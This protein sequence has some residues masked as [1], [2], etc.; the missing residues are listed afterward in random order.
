MIVD[1]EF[2][3]EEAIITYWSIMLCQWELIKFIFNRMFYLGA[4]FTATCICGSIF[5]IPRWFRYTNIFRSSV[6]SLRWIVKQHSLLSWN[7]LEQL[8]TNFGSTF[9]LL[10]FLHLH[11]YL[12]Y[13]LPIFLMNFLTFHILTWS[14][15]TWTNQTLQIK[16]VMI[17]CS[18][19][20]GNLSW[21]IFVL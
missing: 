13:L 11:M 15:F 4:D 8:V 18:Y 19:H 14:A 16:H 17:T 6:A 9:F 5:G 3:K 20:F 2:Y 21:C 10:L 7:V 12:T 1:Y